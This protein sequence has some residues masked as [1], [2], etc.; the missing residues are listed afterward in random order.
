ME[1]IALPLVGRVATIYMEVSE[2]TQPDFSRTVTPMPFEI[3]K[4]TGDERV[5]QRRKRA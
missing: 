3:E 5:E 1:A 2:D 4:V